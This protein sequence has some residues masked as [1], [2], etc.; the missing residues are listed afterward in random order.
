MR[1]NISL[2]ARPWDLNGSC[3][4][5][6]PYIGRGFLCL[7]GTLANVRFDGVNNK[8]LPYGSVSN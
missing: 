6:K 2:R 3:Y 7:R 5:L 1:R 8:M 4:V